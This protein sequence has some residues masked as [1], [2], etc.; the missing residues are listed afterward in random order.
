MMME[1]DSPERHLE[2]RVVESHTEHEQQGEG[3][4]LRGKVKQ[5]CLRVQA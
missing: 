5:I 3:G 2:L 4:S 1:A